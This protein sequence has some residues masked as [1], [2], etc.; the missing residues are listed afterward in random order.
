MVALGRGSEPLARGRRKRRERAL[1]GRKTCPAHG[2]GH[3]V[4]AVRADY[5][6]LLTQAY[7]IDK[8][9]AP[10]AELAYYRSFI[11]GASG[12]VLEAMC[13]SGRFLL[14]LLADGIDIDGVD[15]SPD[16]LLACSRRGAERGLT[17]TLF[18]QHLEQLEL[19]RTYA[20]VFCAGGSFGLIADLEVA[21]EA[22]ERMHRHIEPRG[23]LLLEIETPKSAN[24]GGLW[25]GRFWRREDGAFITLRGNLRAVD[26]YL[27]EGVGIYELFVDGRLEATELNEWTRRFWTSDGIS[28]ALSAAGFRDIQVTAAFA[29]EPP[30]ADASTLSV[31]AVRN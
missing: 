28:A 13:G 8:P 15:S 4:T 24:R 26:E 2:E 7:D 10:P 11:D 20:V 14:P 27:E 31:V 5:R 23:V 22:L 18:E 29:H 9:H 16:M 3:T 1:D 19:R 30:A 17:P 21:A 6:A 25:G 12:P